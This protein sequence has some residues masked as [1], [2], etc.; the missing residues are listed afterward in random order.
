MSDNADLRRLSISGIA[1]GISFLV[2]LL[3]AMPMKY[4]LG[5]PEAVRVVGMLHGVLFIVYAILV[6]SVARSRRWP[7]TWIGM[8]LLSAL[9]PFGPF[10]FDRKIKREAS[11]GRP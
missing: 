9:L 7:V 5:K 4:L 11:S 2:L 3:V 8:G 6:L 1:E 10:W